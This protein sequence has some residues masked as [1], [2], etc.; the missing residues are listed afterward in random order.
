[1]SHRVF[2]LLKH[3]RCLGFLK[4]QKPQLQTNCVGV[5]AEGPCWMSWSLSALSIYL[6]LGSLPKP[7]GHWFSSAAWG[8]LVSAS[9]DPHAR[10]TDDTAVISSDVELRDLKRGAHASVA[11][12]LATGHLLSI[13]NSLWKL[14]GTYE[15]KSENSLRR[16]NRMM[17]SAS[18][19]YS[20]AIRYDNSIIQCN[21]LII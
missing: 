6:I 18:I 12:P 13:I 8:P 15:Y 9:P 7:G 1:M 17:D 16:V 2:P 11:G 21:S 3:R 4:G 10:V 14:R 5:E 20:L 19:W